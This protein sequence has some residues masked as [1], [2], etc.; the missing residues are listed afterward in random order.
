MGIHQLGIAED[1][2]ARPVGDDA[3]GVEQDGPRADFEDHLEVMG[4]DQHRAA[5]SLDEPDESP[6]AAGVEIG[7]RLVEHED[8][9][10]ARQH[11]RQAER[12]SARRS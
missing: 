8:R 7:R 1:L 3:A 9:R 6:A 5:E 10:P 4:G 11:A 2:A 12:A